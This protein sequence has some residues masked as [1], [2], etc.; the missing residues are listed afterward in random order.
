MQQQQQHWYDG[1][2]KSV[3]SA[4]AGN[5][6]GSSARRGGYSITN[7]NISPQ[8][9]QGRRPCSPGA[10]GLVDAAAAVAA[11]LEAERQQAARISTRLRFA[12]DRLMQQVGGWVCVWGLCVCDMG[13]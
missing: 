6:S 8:Q 12:E 13:V 5:S 1:S 10:A 4:P 3:R 7:S 2:P 11:E 9:Q